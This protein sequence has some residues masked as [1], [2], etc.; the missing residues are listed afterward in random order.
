M[1]VCVWKTCL[2]SLFTQLN[3]QLLEELAADAY[4]EVDRR[5]CDTSQ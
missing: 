5:E 4:D 3:N 2:H 1:C